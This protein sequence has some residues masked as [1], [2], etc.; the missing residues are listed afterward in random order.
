MIDTNYNKYSLKLVHNKDIH[1][2]QQNNS[3]FSSIY[4]EII[5]IS[6]NAPLYLIYPT[7]QLQ[8][9]A[10]QIK[11]L[12]LQLSN[13]LKQYFK[14]N[15]ENPLK[16]LK[17]VS[18]SPEC[19]TVKILEQPVT[20][21]SYDI[22]IQQIAKGQRNV[23]NYVP[24]KVCPFTAQTYSFSIQADS[25]NLDFELQVKN[26]S[27]NEEILTQMA[28]LINRTASNL[29]AELIDDGFKVSLSI[30]A[31]A[32][33]RNQPAHFSIEDTTPNGLISFYGLNKTFTQ[34]TPS[35]FSVNGEAFH[36]FGIAFTIDGLFEMTLLQTVPDNI[37]VAFELDSTII[38]EEIQK[39]QFSLNRLLELARSCQKHTLETELMEFITIHKEDLLEIGIELNKSNLLITNQTQLENSISNS[40]VQ[41]FFSEHQNF[42]QDLLAQTH[43]ISTDPLKYVPN[44]VVSYKNLN[45]INYPNPY[46]ISSYSGFLFTN[47]C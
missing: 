40:T 43:E 37:R 5:N 9:F 14:T 3:E 33:R 21:K 31:N 11:D 36:S 18:P 24:K 27:S 12:S 41:T 34:P 13:T 26:S 23:G 46:Q 1:A 44:K 6:R 38:T 4:H 45:K 10:I 7:S 8:T 39:F 35:E 42:S 32:H 19:L 30:S 2:Y 16:K 15:M 22:T 28:S 17:L 20:P 29:D 25:E 47:Y